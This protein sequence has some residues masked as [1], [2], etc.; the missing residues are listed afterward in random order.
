MQF[1]QFIWFI[2]ASILLTW[3]F[4]GN[5]FQRLPAN[6]M[7]ATCRP[8]VSSDTNY[9]DGWLHHESH[10]FLAQ[11]NTTIRKTCQAEFRLMMSHV[12]WTFIIPHIDDNANKTT[13]NSNVIVLYYKFHRTNW[14]P[15]HRI[16]C[17]KCFSIDRCDVFIS[18]RRFI[19]SFT[20]EHT[21]LSLFCHP[22]FG[23][24]CVCALFAAFQFV[25]NSDL[26]V[27]FCVLLLQISNVIQ[28]IAHAQSTQLLSCCSFNG[29]IYMQN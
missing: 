11:L 15:L 7:I 18:I 5:H 4:I 1:S 19:G 14:K 21:K 20:L 8:N 9:I 27:F 23:C 28:C 16:V 2:F 3:N 29:Q 6:A 10:Q 13:R 12:K 25:V 17:A 26:L 24:V 22:F